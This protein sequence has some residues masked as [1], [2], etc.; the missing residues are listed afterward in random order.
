M[1]PLA[2]KL[3]MLK[4][5][6]EGE[7]LEYRPGSKVR[8]G[9]VVRGNN[10][11]IKD[12]GISTNHLTIDSESGKWVLRD[13]HSSNGT[14]VNDTKLPP[15]NPLDLNDGDEIKIGEY[16]SFSVKIDRHEES[17]LRRNPR[18]GAAS[19]TGPV[20]ENR[21]RRGRVAKESE[22]KSELDIENEEEIGGATD[23][24]GPAAENRGRRGRVAK[25]NEVKSDL[26][27]E[28]EEI[29]L[30]ENPRRGRLRKARVLKSEDT[31]E[32]IVVPQVSLRV[33]RRS[34]NVEP[35]VSDSAL[36]EI[37]ENCSVD[38]EEV[39][40]EPKRRGGGRRRKNVP[41]ELPVCDKGDILEHKDLGE[42]VP[43]DGKN[44]DKG[45]ASKQKDLGET[46]LVDLKDNGDDDDAKG[47]NLVEER[48]E[49]AA[50]GF[51]V[52]K[53]DN[54]DE[55]AK[56][57]N[58]GCEEAAIDCNVGESGDKDESGNRSCS[59]VSDAKDVDENGSGSS[60]KGSLGKVGQ[61]VDL[62]KMTLDDWFDYVEVSWPKV[63]IDEIDK[64]CVGM[65]EK[66]KQV[67]EYIAQH[68]EKSQG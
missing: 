39:K 18:R 2:L 63:V 10:L 20:A 9:R 24:V 46:V 61:E 45:D 31:V 65:R 43:V 47:L 56:R 60:V 25:K 42:I 62:E 23:K 64:I 16:T 15:N 41:E 36:V 38:C 21:G 55:E 26:E 11:P 13:L 34:K 28:S 14:I 6:R 1:E 50:I 51:N 53:S 40:I 57:L 37:L 66:A 48:H 29:E 58:L 30:V 35:V 33:T 4:G 19:N 5:P 12:S 68:K 8:I 59:G 54:D 67:Q 44:D 32:E 49:E 7:T 27:K 3:V 52:R 22:V 17:R